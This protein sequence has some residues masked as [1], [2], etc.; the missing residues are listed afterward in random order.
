MCMRNRSNVL[1][2]EVALYTK[3][4]STTPQPHPACTTWQNIYGQVNYN[5]RYH[6]MCTWSSCSLAREFSLFSETA[7]L[8]WVEEDES[9]KWRVEMVSVYNWLGLLYCW[10]K[11]LLSAGTFSP[12]A[13]FKIYLPKGQ[14]VRAFSVVRPKIY[15][16]QA[17]GRVGISSPEAQNPPIHNT[18]QTKK[19]KKKK[20][21]RKKETKSWGGG[22]GQVGG[23]VG[24]S[25]LVNNAA[26]SGLFCE[27]MWCNSG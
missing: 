16:S 5:Q 25:V 3:T 19:K 1:R 14:V 27:W 26:S 9:E 12:I 4:L 2:R 17:I 21:T 18:I 10:M 7:H 20:K 24:G 15:L 8:G 23:G 11:S 13:V 22:G 6:A